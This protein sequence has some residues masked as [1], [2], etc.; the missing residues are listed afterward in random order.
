LLLR[1]IWAILFPVTTPPRPGRRLLDLRSG[2]WVVLLAILLSTGV[3]SWRVAEILK[4]RKGHAVGD[5]KDPE[6]YGFD[7]SR[8]AVPA[9]SIVASGLPKDG[10]HAIDA[11]AILTAGQVDAL[12][13]RRKLLVS[14]DRVIGLMVAG[15]A[16]AYPTRILNWHEV[17]NDTLGGVP[18]AVTYSP[19]CDAAVAF[20][21]R[22]GGE[23]L[24]FGVS[25]LLMNSNLIMYDARPDPAG[26]SLWSQLGFRAIAGPASGSRLTLVPV[27]L[28]SWGEWREMHPGTTVLAPVPGMIDQYKADPYGSYFGTPTL[29]FPVD[30]PP[31]ADGPAPK[32]P[33]VAFRPASSASAWTAV[34]VPA[35]VERGGFEGVLDGAFDGAPVRLQVRSDP[36]TARVSAD[37]APQ[38]VYAFWFAWHAFH[39]EEGRPSLW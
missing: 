34:S 22:L 1:V 32:T 25:G 19:L 29:R 12:K 2:G 6:T 8:V 23:T 24:R 7:L 13:G 9:E 5:G 26:E 21:R 18:I 28:V 3:F 38:T 15:R 20:D 10:I 27:A 35:V 33:I 4:T 11:P 31:P 36:P 16:R 30:P 14:S 39:P 37:P 17:V